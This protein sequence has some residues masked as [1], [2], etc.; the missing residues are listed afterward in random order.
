[1]S[2]FA[3]ISEL[4]ALRIW[5]GVKA[6][7]VGGEG[8][9]VAVVELDPSS[10]VPEHSHPHEQIGVCVAGSMS[11]RAGEEERE[12][13]PGDSWSIPGGLPHE[14]RVGPEGAVVIESWSPPRDD[15]AELGEAEPAPPSW[16]R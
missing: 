15:W 10:V 3:G 4:S 6:R 13:G 12:V 7:L 8:V 5:D 11:F 9:T 1:M 16:P 14:V 2:V